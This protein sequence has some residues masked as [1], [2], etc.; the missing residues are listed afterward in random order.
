MPPAG[1]GHSVEDMSKTVLKIAGILL[2]AWLIFSVLG[3]ILSTVKFFLLVGLI[4]AVV[5][6]V[7]TLITK[8]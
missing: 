6:L 1:P 3:A 7:V 8:R 4:A 2:A 5:M